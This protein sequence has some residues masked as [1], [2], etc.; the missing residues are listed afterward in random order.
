MV[1]YSSWREL[2]G[3]ITLG[4]W[5]LAHEALVALGLQLRW[6][7]L[8]GTMP[9]HEAMTGPPTTRPLYLRCSSLVF[10]LLQAAVSSWYHCTTLRSAPI[11][12]SWATTRMCLRALNIFQRHLYMHLL[13][14]L[15][16]FWLSHRAVVESLCPPACH[17]TIRV[18]MWDEERSFLK[19]V[20]GVLPFVSSSHNLTVQSEYAPTCLVRLIGTVSAQ[21]CS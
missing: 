15:K 8:G 16:C 4:V 19:S 20:V 9:W 11:T 13:V 14:R 5:M 21:Q 6:W 17:S 2:R 18:G 3:S 1:N 10:D 12:F 7:L